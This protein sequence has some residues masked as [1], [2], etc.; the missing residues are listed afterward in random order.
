MVFNA[1]FNNSSFISWRSAL[2]VQETGVPGET[3][4]L[5]QVTHKLYHM[6]LYLTLYIIYTIKVM[7]LQK[8]VPRGNITAVHRSTNVMF[9]VCPK[10]IRICIPELQS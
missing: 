10:C 4:D 6:L 5:P 1:T 3:T 2:L 8:L 9:H 7:F